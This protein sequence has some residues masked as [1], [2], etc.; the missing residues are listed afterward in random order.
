[1]RLSGHF[2]RDDDFQTKIHNLSCVSWSVAMYHSTLNRFIIEISAMLC[3]GFAMRVSGN[4]WKKI[5]CRVNLA[6]WLWWKQKTFLLGYILYVEPSHNFF[7]SLSVF[8]VPRFSLSLFSTNQF[9][10][11][12]TTS[13]WSRGHHLYSI[14]V[15]KI[16]RATI[17]DASA[18]KNV[19]VWPVLVQI[20]NV[21]W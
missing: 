3:Y 8:S 12:V 2:K 15:D 11:C 17:I 4:S 16:T 6:V 21:R 5:N 14:M 13:K 10:S 19:N 7:F 9:K 20:L 1:M 18:G